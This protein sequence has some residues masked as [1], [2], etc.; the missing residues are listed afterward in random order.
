MIGGRSKD[1]PKNSTGGVRGCGGTG[2]VGAEGALN[3]SVCLETSGPGE[4]NDVHKVRSMLPINFAP[5]NL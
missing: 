2:R 1:H 4:K 3:Y 5:K